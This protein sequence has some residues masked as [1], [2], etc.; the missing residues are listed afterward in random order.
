VSY[1][2]LGVYNEIRGKSIIQHIFLCLPF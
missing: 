2:T 1:A